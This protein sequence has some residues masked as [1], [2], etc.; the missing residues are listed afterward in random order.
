MKFKYFGSIVIALTAIFFLG[1]C[2]KFLDI[3]GI[4]ITYLPV[5]DAQ[6]PTA[7]QVNPRAEGPG[8]LSSLCSLD[9][10]ANEREASARIKHGL[11]SVYISGT[12]VN[13]MGR[14]F[15]RSQWYGGTSRP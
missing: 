13:C 1:S 11:L 15:R 12:D 8:D 14:R 5:A 10:A 4:Q 9:H 6:E 7:A 2:K 3:K